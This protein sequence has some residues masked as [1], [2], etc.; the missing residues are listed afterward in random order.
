MQIYVVVVSVIK[1]RVVWTGTFK[2]YVWLLNRITIYDTGLVMQLT[3]FP[4]VGCFDD[5]CDTFLRFWSTELVLNH[6][7]FWQGKGEF[8]MEYFQHA[9]APQDAQAV[10]VKEYTNKRVS[11]NM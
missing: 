3:S 9:A 6:Y 11:V 5:S 2:Q 8:T 1:S 4:L 10:L 7:C